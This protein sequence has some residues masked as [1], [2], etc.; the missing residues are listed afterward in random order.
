MRN[1][2]GGAWAPTPD[3]PSRT[4]PAITASPRDRPFMPSLL[5]RRS[6]RKLESA[7]ILALPAIELDAI[8]QTERTK[9][10]QPAHA[11]AGVR[12][13]IARIE[14]GPESVH[15]SGIHKAGQPDVERQ[16][17]EVFDVAEDLA[18]AADP[19]T[20][21]VDGGDLAELPP[22]QGVGTA[23]VEPLEDGPLFRGPAERVAG[24]GAAGED[25]VEP[26]GLEVG[27]RG[28]PSHELGI[29]PESREVQRHRRLA[30]AR[31]RLEVV[32]AVARDG[33]T[34]HRRHVRP[35]LLEQIGREDAVGDVADVVA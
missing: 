24:L 4:A 35:L 19:E 5:K 13:D 31:G 28:D 8:V 14:L 22:S 7:E 21:G 33:A 15:V 30:P 16:R 17:N 20:G 26:D 11:A 27:R 34:D 9:G 25:V 1:A 18:R 12:A 3:P 23:Q 2:A 32:T 6:D 29:A 10:R